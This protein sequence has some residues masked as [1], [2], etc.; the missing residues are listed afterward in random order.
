MGDPWYYDCLSLQP[1][2]QV[3]VVTSRIRVR[4]QTAWGWTATGLCPLLH[5]RKKWRVLEK[6]KR[7]LDWVRE[8]SRP[9]RDTSVH[10]T[11][12]MSPAAPSRG[13]LNPEQHVPQALC[14][15]RCDYLPEQLL[16]RLRAI[17]SSYFLPRIHDSPP[18]L[19]LFDSLLSLPFPPSAPSRPYSF[20]PCTS[21]YQSVT[22]LGLVGWLDKELSRL[23]SPYPIDQIQFTAH[24]DAGRSSNVE[25]VKLSMATYKIQ[26]LLLLLLVLWV[27]LSLLLLLILRM[28]LMLLLLLVSQQCSF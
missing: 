11:I 19:P 22:I 17:I 12:H 18:S 4:V 2:K 7:T 14:L 16:K 3:V 25:V 9:M 15:L 28:I 24:G 6:I 20:S 1:E 5:L 27:L 21:T 26:L 10:S 13:A 23:Q 8:G